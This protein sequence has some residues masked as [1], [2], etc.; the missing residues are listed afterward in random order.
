M[1]YLVSFTANAG[2]VQTCAYVD[3]GKRTFMDGHMNLGLSSYG[4]RSNPAIIKNKG[5]WNERN[6]KYYNLIDTKAYRA[7]KFTI[8]V[9]SVYF[10]PRIIVTNSRKMRFNSHPIGKFSGGWVSEVEFET[11]PNYDHE[12]V[13]L[14][15]TT[16]KRRHSQDLK[17]A[18][19]RVRGVQ[20]DYK[21]IY[22]P[23]DANYK[24]QVKFDDRNGDGIDDSNCP[25][26]EMSFLGSCT[27]IP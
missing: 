25:I 13:K 1:F 20:R 2:S 17:G 27:P 12:P 22:A 11:R 26:G 9:Q 10:E 15:F 4:D 23:D 14:Y 21:C 3:E 19:F 6:G 24:P 8:R 18:E 16:A 7:S 5:Y